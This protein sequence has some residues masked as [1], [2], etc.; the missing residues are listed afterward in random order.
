MKKIILF[1]SITFMAGVAFANMYNSIVDTTSW[2]SNVPDSIVVFRQYFHS[3]NPGNFFRVFSPINQLLALLSVVLFWKVS[4]KARLFLIVAFLLAVLGDVVTFAYFYPRNDM[5]M[6]LP[7]Q[8][9]TDKF[10]EILKQWRAMNWVRTI[11]ILIGLLFSCLG[12]H[13][14]YKQPIHNTVRVNGSI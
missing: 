5:L 2:I 10:M 8:G 14:I 7:L 1:L 9:N 3:I 11:I 6:N 4:P 13:E 12:L